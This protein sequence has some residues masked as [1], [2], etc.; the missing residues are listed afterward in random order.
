MQ[1]TMSGSRHKAELIPQVLRL[2]ILGIIIYGVKDTQ[3][4][5]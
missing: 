1:V 5:E 2:R 4:K 3:K